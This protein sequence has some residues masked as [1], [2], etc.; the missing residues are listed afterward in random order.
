MLSRR[1]V[2]MLRTELDVK[3]YFF[4]IFRLGR[5]QYGDLQLLQFLG[6]LRTPRK[7]GVSTP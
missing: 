7:L 2:L 4:V 5:F 1:S 6:K 3:D